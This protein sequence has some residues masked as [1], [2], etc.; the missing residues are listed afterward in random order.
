MRTSADKQT[1]I[2]T[3]TVK[4]CPDCYTNLTLDAVFCISC[5][6]KVGKVDKLGMARRPVDWRAYTICGISWLVFI[7]Y[8]WWAFF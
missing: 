8:V 4:K 6:K 3:F 1:K 7:L 2:Q 5:F